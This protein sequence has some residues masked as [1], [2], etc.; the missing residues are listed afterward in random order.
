MPRI[1]KIAFVLLIAVIAIGA[2]QMASSDAQDRARE[3][4]LAAAQVEPDEIP[5]AG[6]VLP[7]TK[8][9]SYEWVYSSP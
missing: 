8:I 9:E 1:A 7:V 6:T 2:R 4:S 5:R 3:P